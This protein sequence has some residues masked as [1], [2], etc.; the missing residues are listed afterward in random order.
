MSHWSL[1]WWLKSSS[2]LGQ[3]AAPSQQTYPKM[4][5]GSDLSWPPSVLVGSS[6]SLFQA[7]SAEKAP[8]SGNCAAWVSHWAQRGQELGSTAGLGLGTV[9]E[10]LVWRSSCAAAGVACLSLCSKCPLSA[11]GDARCPGTHLLWEPVC[12]PVPSVCLLCSQRQRRSCAGAQHARR[13]LALW[14]WQPGPQRGLAKPA[15]EGGWCRGSSD[16][17]SSPSSHGC[18]AQDLG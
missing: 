18:F 6:A 10:G 13:C 4:S 12:K 8:R 7:P 17:P 1:P 14:L 9:A 3:S 2:C 15:L 5:L 16:G 11:V